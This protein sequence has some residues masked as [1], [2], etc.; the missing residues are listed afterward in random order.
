MKKFQKVFLPALLVIGLIGWL[1]RSHIR[2]L[3]PTKMTFQNTPLTNL[4]DKQPVTINSLK[5]NVVIVSY[6]Q[7]WCGDCAR[8]TPVLNELATKLQGE[9]FK[10][11]YVSHEDEAKVS[12]FRQRFASDKISFLK[13]QQGPADFGIR[14][15]PTTFLI[16]KNGEVVKTKS[17]GYDWLAEET[18]IRKMLAE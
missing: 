11:L 1:G 7:T 8:E 10:V 18:S 9:S 15:Y 16:N 5:G 4:D 14:V 12:N 2:N 6:Y 13:S 3:F 17:E